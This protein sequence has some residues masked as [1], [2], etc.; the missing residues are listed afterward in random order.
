MHVVCLIA[1]LLPGGKETLAEADAKSG[2]NDDMPRLG[3]AK[4]FDAPYGADLNHPTQWGIGMQSFMVA[5]SLPAFFGMRC[6]SSSQPAHVSLRNIPSVAALILTY[7]AGMNIVLVLCGIAL[8]FYCARRYEDHPYFALYG[9]AASVSF[10]IV[11]IFNTYGALRAP[12]LYILNH[13]PH[14]YET[15]ILIHVRAFC[16]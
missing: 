4:S 14:H 13:I 8:G 2:E 1:H 3:R 9:G 10:F 11:S 16:M 5:E 12:H 15:F 7:F 6:G